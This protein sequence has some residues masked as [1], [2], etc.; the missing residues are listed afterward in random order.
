MFI[1]ISLL[2]HIFQGTLRHFYHSLHCFIFSQLSQSI[3]LQNSKLISVSM[4][5][6]FKKNHIDDTYLSLSRYLS[7]HYLSLNSLNLC[8][9]NMNDIIITVASIIF[10]KLRNPI[11]DHL[12][13]N[14]NYSNSKYVLHNTV[15]ISSLLNHRNCILFHELNHDFHDTFLCNIHHFAFKKK[16]LCMMSEYLQLIIK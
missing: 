3:I 13:K 14:Q 9:I 5:S 10:E 15:L 11:S 1:P 4:Q 6:K 12:F 2:V 7:C 8:N 16:Q